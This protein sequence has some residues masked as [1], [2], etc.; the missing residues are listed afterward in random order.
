MAQEF[1]SGNRDE[2]SKEGRVD[3]RGLKAARVETECEDADGGVKGFARE[4]VPVDGRAEA[5]VQ[6]D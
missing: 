2:K 5:G 1:D 3:L 6:G 4:F